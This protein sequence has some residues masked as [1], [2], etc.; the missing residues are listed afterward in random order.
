MRAF[1]QSVLIVACCVAAAAGA[2]PAAMG[3]RLELF[4]DG[5]LI[6]ATSGDVTQVLHKPEPKEVVLVTDSPWEGN[7]SAYY[8]IFRDGDR[9]RMYYRGSHYDEQA[10]KS[11]HPEVTCYAESQDGIHWTKPRL[12]LCEFD[13]SKENNIVWD[14]IGTHCFVAFK[15][16]NPDCPAESRYKGIASGEPGGKRGLYVFQSPDGIHWKLAHGEPVITV[17]AFDSQ[18][19]AF[20]D[21]HTRQYREYHRTFVEGKRAIM[22]GISRDFIAWTAPVLLTYPGSPAEHLYTNAVQP[23]ERAPHI[24]IGFPTRF[25]PDQ[26]QRVE[27]TFMASRDGVTFH[28]W[29]EP[30]IPET[31][32]QDRGGNRSN[33]MAWGLVELPGR[34]NHLSVYAT[35][36]YY[37]GPDSRL[38][39]F[40]YRKDGF[41]SVRG[42]LRGG[43]LATRLVTLSE[44]CQRLVVNFATEEDGYVR[45]QLE[46]A[47][48]AGLPGYQFADCTALKG[49][50]IA[51]PVVW[52][53]GSDLHAL[54]GRTIRLRFQL[55]NADLYAIRL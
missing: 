26:G 41:V 15:D 35:E 31:A 55:Q 1:S 10:R 20:W 19:L 22:T 23:Y 43:E 33:Y 42:G 37:T 24:L 45:V 14:G 2:E 13:G 34:P 46:T 16:G 28:R 8:T 29:L 50:S 53:Q 47:D 12:G 4:V 21:P 44:A 11:A 52:K 30:V 39:R 6:E 3:D 27:P 48:G 49:D 40:E 17:G 18:N 25:H 54:A 7:T 5:F 38:R 36:A 32:P 51:A 9:Y